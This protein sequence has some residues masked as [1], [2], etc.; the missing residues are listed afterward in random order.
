MDYSKFSA[1]SMPC[2]A[3]VS[4]DN[5]ELSKRRKSLWCEQ[6]FDTPP[7]FPRISKQKSTPFVCLTGIL[8]SSST[9]R[10]YR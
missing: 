5:Q 6:H 4:D 1:G 3:E 7:P 2:D 10:L 9:A 8:K